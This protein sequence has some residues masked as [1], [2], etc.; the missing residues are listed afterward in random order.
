M[1]LSE[2]EYLKALSELMSE[3]ASPE[4]EEAWHDL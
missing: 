3:W 4:D 1:E 2:R